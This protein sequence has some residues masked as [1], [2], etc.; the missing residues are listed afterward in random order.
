MNRFTPHAAAALLGLTVLGVQGEARARADQFSLGQLQ[1]FGASWCPAQWSPA[2]GSLLA[3]AENTALYSL[4]G[5][6]F[7]GDGVTTFA[8]PD[9][10]DR[11]PTGMSNVS[12]LGTASGQT[13]AT[14]TLAQLPMHGHGF[15]GDPTPPASNSPAD[16]MM[17][18]FPTVQPVYAPTTA[19]PDTP[20]NAGMAVP[21][22]G[23]QPLP[24]QM[25][26]LAVNWCI[27]LEGVFPSR[28]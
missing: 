2:D 14:L 1:Q 5:T 25:P 3:I 26:A 11:A 9:L 15:N 13:A 20:M 8:L 19:T 7:G 12:V 28:P 16:S 23:S 6:Q 18:L 4:I 27:A 10:R 24:T 21:A 22:G 17:G